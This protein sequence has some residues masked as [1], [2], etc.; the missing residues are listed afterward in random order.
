MKKYLFT[1]LS[2]GVAG[3]CFAAFHPEAPTGTSVNVTQHHNNPSRDGLYIDPAFTMA[4]A[5]NLTRDLSFNGTIV[6]NVYSQ[7]LYVEGGPSGP[8][9]I[10]AT[11]SNNVYALKVSDG[12]PLWQRNVGTPATSMGNISPCGITGTPVVDLASRSL[13]FDAVIAGPNNL[14]FSLNVDTGA[15]NPGWPVDVNAR[16][17][18]FN[19]QRQSQRSALG[20]L[21]GIVYVPYGGYFGDATPYFGRVLGVQIIDPAATIGS[22]ATT[23]SRAGIWAPGGI[24]SDGTNLFVTTGNGAGGVTWAGSE[25]VIRLLPGPSFTNSTTDY[26]A[27]TNWAA[28]DSSDADLGGSGPVLVDV[29]GAAP[30]ALVAQYGKD[31]NVYLLN[32]NNL[33]GVSA[34]LSTVNIGG[35]GIQAGAAYRTA[36]A[37]YVVFRPTTNTLTA[38]RI[39]ATNP[40]ALQSAWSVSS[41]GRGSPFITSTDGTNNVIVWAVG[42]GGDSRLHGHNGDTGAVVFNGGGANELM[43]GT[44][45]YNTAA[46]A[47]R[48]RIYVANDNKVFAFNVPAGGTTPTPTPTV[49]PPATPTV[50]PPPT[51]T[52]TPPSPTPTPT[53]TVAPTA[54]PTPST[55]PTP[56]SP[57]PTPPCVRFVITLNGARVVPPTASAA[58]GTGVIEVNT[59]ANTLTY[60]ITF[61]GLSSAET[62]AHIHGF[63]G[64]GQN[65]PIIHTLPLGSPKIG[66]FN[67]SEAQEFFILNNLSYVDIH[68]VNFP[69]GE[70]RGQISGPTTPCATPTPTAT[71][72]ATPSPTATASATIAPTPSPTLSPGITPSPTPTATATATIAPTPSPT[73]SPGITPS[74]TPTATATATAAP[75]ATPGQA[76]NLSTRMFVQAGDNAGIGGF[77]ISGTA[78]KHVLVRVIGPSLTQFGVTNALADP[79]LEVHGPAPFATINNDNWQRRS[80]PGRGHFGH[81]SGPEQQSRVGY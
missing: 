56:V 28:L 5:A 11:E 58:T 3:L 70:I 54:S 44:R 21:G 52:P 48:G 17:S 45:G 72:T 81:G 13:F 71:A 60:N 31:D 68:S 67:Y 26:W 74:P 30:S 55:N 51:P 47:A 9:V 80:R 46:I 34:P 12:L 42:S 38:L 57:S 76:V 1:I 63:G 20:I 14:I 23:S 61:S 79:T 29:P 77:I 39:T 2:V 65:A 19:S 69:D 33:G 10:V 78:P 32:R 66:V 50:T 16:I 6:G 35:S 40:P 27:P 41:S 8:V 59:V 62:M 18:G 22:F 49:T 4:A 37:T 24:A 15:T 53:A 73:L 64:T 36:T 75:T 7:P 25:A 43:T